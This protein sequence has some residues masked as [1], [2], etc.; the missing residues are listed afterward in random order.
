MKRVHFKTSDEW[1]EWLKSNHDKENEM[2][3]IFFKKETGE[4]SI[5]YEA[6]VE[7]A[8]CFG[9]IDSIIKKIDE[10][11]YVRKFTPRK[12]SSKWSE[13]NKNRIAKLIK[14]NRMTEVGLVKIE[15]A[16]RNGLWD[17][18]DR[19]NIQFDIPKEFQSALNKNQKAKE[20]F[21]QLAPTYQKQYIGWIVIAKRQETRER[22]IKESIDL[23]EKGQKLGLK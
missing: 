12:D 16:K 7:E 9:W 5:E 18:P 15:T 13:L 11:R 22:R 2:W 14:N 21:N 19:P 20:N 23:L 8:L 3:L 1:R 10:K 4:P 17:K 6:A